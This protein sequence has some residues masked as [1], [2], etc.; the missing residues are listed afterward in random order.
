MHPFIL[1]VGPTGSGKSALALNL[2]ERL[3]AAILN[4][5]SLQTYQRLNIGT[6]KPSPEERQLVPH[7]LFDILKPGEVLTAGDYRKMAL[8][9]LAR[10]LPTRPVLGVGG[11]GFYIQALEKG[12]F[13]VPKPKPE[14]EEQ[15]R[16]ENAK[17]GLAHMYELLTQLDPEYAERI[18]P[19]D[20]YRILRAVIIIRDSGKRVSDLQ[21]SFKG[22]PFPFPLIKVGLMPTREEL[23]PRVESR[24]REMLAAGFLDEV[25]A[26]LDEGFGEWPALQSVGYKECCAYLK[27]DVSHEKLLPLIVEKTMQLAKKQK[28]WFKRDAEIQWLPFANPEPVL[29]DILARFLDRQG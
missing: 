6:A 10:E 4:C 27:G 25:K 15:V 24:T 26:L 22:T 14:I 28:T 13:D 11:S 2:A 18:S 1:I 7:F 23:L 9:I 19:N 3:D 29:R 8:E 5:D 12:M 17:S 20:S 21:K 16:A